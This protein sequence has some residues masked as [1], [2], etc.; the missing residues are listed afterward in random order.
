VASGVNST[1]EGWS[2]QSYDEDLL[3]KVQKVDLEIAKFFVSFCK[4]HNILCYFCGGGC[5]GAVRHK[6]FIPWDDDLDFFIPRDDYENLKQMWKDTDRYALLYP[7][8]KYNDH[9]MYITLRDKS[10]TMIK[11]YQ[12]D[13][14][15]VHGISID[16][17]PL[18]GYPNSK[19]Q[20]CWQVFWGLTYQLFCAQ[21]VPE[22]HGKV[23]TIL[24]KTALGVLRSN[25]LRCRIWKKAEQEMTKY[26]IVDCDAITEICAGPRYMKNR[27]PK[28]LFKEAIFVPFEDTEMPIPVGYDGYLKM[29]FGDYM[30]YPP[31]EEQVP[32]HDAVFIDPDET[33][34]SYKGKY[35]CTK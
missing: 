5:I 30:S 20:R 12:K 19:I 28:E 32:S 21:V 8:E 31:E 7:T 34:R 2:M 17:F 13:I 18:D 10:T 25:K 35:Y 11:P 26:R 16:I 3:K 14:D 1:L 24:G 33:Y 6:G 27:Y 29:A 15:T 4:E 22:N 23:T 9:C